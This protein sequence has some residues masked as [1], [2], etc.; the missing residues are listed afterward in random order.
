MT[1]NRQL[2]DITLHIAVPNSISTFSDP[3]SPSIAT[4]GPQNK[5][6]QVLRLFGIAECQPFLQLLYR[7]VAAGGLYE[8]T[9][10]F[11]TTYLNIRLCGIGK[12]GVQAWTKFLQDQGS[13]M[14]PSKIQRTWL[15][16]G[17]TGV[18]GTF[19]SSIK[20]ETDVIGFMRMLQT[21]A[22]AGEPL[23]VVILIWPVN[24]V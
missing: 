15:P 7:R 12:Y 16:D 8:P 22:G 3:D 1:S 13:K 24:R 18:L 19:I 17:T 2:E 14:V 10:N 9:P 4:T 23:E 21:L 20:D 6:I 11:T 5:P